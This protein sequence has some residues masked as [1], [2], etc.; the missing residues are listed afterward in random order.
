MTRA[1][2]TVLLACLMF[3]APE[4]LVSWT[5]SVAEAD[6]EG[7]SATAPIDAVVKGLENFAKW[8]HTFNLHATKRRA[9]RVIIDYKPDHPRA[10]KW[11]GYKRNKGGR[12][13]RNEKW[14]PTPDRK[15]RAFQRIPGK[16]KSYLERPASELWSWIQARG[17]NLDEVERKGLVHLLTLLMPGTPEYEEAYG[18]IKT[19]TG[20][21][22]PESI[23]FLQPKRPFRSII[24]SHLNRVGHGK[25]VGISKTAE[26]LSSGWTIGVELGPVTVCSQGGASAEVARITR[27]I[28]ALDSFFRTTWGIE[29]GTALKP[30]TVLVMP[31]GA[32]VDA[33]INRFRIKDSQKEY[34]KGLAGFWA[35]GTRCVVAAS[36]W[37]DRRIDGAVRQAVNRGFHNHYSNLDDIVGISEGLETYLSECLTGTRLTIFVKQTRYTTDDGETERILSDDDDWFQIA[38]ERLDSGTLPTVYQALS[39]SLNSMTS[40][41]LLTSYVLAAYLMEGR[42]EPWGKWMAALEDNA[43]RFEDG[44]VAAFGMDIKTIQARLDRWLREIR[45]EP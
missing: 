44:L 21:L 7:D 36:S 45:P 23:R 24:R 6:T 18:A 19:P 26:R 2:G 1:F 27:S 5:G 3:M 10:R 40:A 4:S 43:P 32:K 41:E 33:M 37:E 34:L 12:W 13:K 29:E 8:C 14:K 30:F 15:G 22:L 25:R 9:A 20:Y 16:R 31:D 35:P 28:A 17:S 39:C 38:R 11:L 42:T